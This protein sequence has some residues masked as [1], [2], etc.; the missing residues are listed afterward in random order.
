[1]EPV[2]LTEAVCANCGHRIIKAG[3]GTWVHDESFP[4][5]IYGSRG[6]RSAAYDRLG[7]WDDSLEPWWTAEPRDGTEKLA[8][9]RDNA[10]E[11][12]ESPEELLPPAV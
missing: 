3:G 10:P 9:A 5:M 2:D 8:A 6:C 11:P 1:M 12:A 7:E 4:M